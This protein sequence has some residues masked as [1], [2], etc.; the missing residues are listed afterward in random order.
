MRRNLLYDNIWRNFIT[1]EKYLSNTIILDPII[2]KFEIN[3]IANINSPNY[4]IDKNS[5][6]MEN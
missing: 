1:N 5:N 2:D 6:L 3:I 4:A